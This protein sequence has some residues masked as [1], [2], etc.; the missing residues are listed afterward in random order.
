MPSVINPRS[1]PFPVYS[2]ASPPTVDVGI[3][4]I[5]KTGVDF[6]TAATTDLFTVPAGRNYQI[7]YSTYFVTAVTSGGAGSL[8][9]TKIQES[10]AS[11]QIAGTA[12]SNSLTPVAFQW[13]FSPAVANTTLSTCS[14]G[15]KVQL[16]LA[17]SN[18]GSTAVTGTVFLIGFY[19]Q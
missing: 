18:A 3:F 14:A 13:S 9:V 6:K 15:N 19:V 7:L 12:S 1:G 10:S 8:V 11:R 5:A 4:V 2:S 16:V 17:A